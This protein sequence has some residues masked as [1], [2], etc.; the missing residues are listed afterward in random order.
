MSHSW[1]DDKLDVPGAAAAGTLSALMCL[2]SAISEV[3]IRGAFG[4]YHICWDGDIHDLDLPPLEI[5]DG[6]YLTFRGALRAARR[7]IRKD[8]RELHEECINTQW[9]Q[10]N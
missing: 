8:R 4:S 3:R 1:K 2:P 5:S 7:K 10:Q 6:P 9:N